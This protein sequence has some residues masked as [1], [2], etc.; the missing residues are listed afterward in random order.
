MSFAVPRSR[1]AWG[2]IFSVAAFSALVV[3]LWCFAAPALAQPTP[4]PIPGDFHGIRWRIVPDP[5][6]PDTV[7]SVRFLACRCNVQLVSGELTAQGVVVLHAQVHPSTV[8]AP[9]DLDSLDVALGKLAAGSYTQAVQI[10]ADLVDSLGQTH[11]E[12]GN[13]SAPFMVLQSCKPPLPGR[14]LPFLDEVKIGRGAP[15]ATCPQTACAGDSIPVHLSGHFPTTCVTL[16]SVKVVPSM[17]VGPQPEPDQIQITYATNTCSG[18]PCGDVV[19]PWQADVKITA[20]PPMPYGLVVATFVDDHCTAGTPKPAGETTLPF[21]VA[22]CESIPSMACFDARFVQAMGT[23]CDAYISPGQ[24]AHVTYE[25]A[26]TTSLA[27][28][29]GAFVFNQ[30]GFK[31]S[32]IQTTGAS[33]GMQLFWN[34][35]PNGAHFVL[36]SDHGELIPPQAPVWTN[37]WEPILQV[38]VDKIVPPPPSGGGGMAPANSVPV[39]PPAPVRLEAQD[40]LAA[41]SLG[42]AVP[43]CPPLPTATTVAQDR[44]ATI[45]PAGQASECDVNHDGRADVRDLVIMAMCIT[46]AGACPDTTG[47][48]LDCDGNG[49]V[50]LA[51]VMCCAHHILDQKRSGDDDQGDDDSHVAVDMSMPRPVTGGCDVPVA[52]HGMS[53][54]GAARL[55]LTFPSDRYDVTGVDLPSSPGW[56]SLSQ[57]GDGTVALAWIAAGSAASQSD[58]QYATIHL[59]LKAGATD[60]G[61]LTVSASQFASKSGGALRVSASGM[62]LPLSGGRVAL[63]SPLPNPSGGRTSFS[64]MLAQPG[65]L[66]VGVF[67]A[68]GRRIATLYHGNAPA[69]A[70]MMSWDGRR[71]S[72]VAAGAGLFFVRAESAGT[73]VTQKV[74]LLSPR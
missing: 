59:Q 62:S 42:H 29:Q 50:D 36:Y 22:P 23:V 37:P 71:D 60:G 57:H 9:C 40:L 67:D 18:Q 65:A 44:A 14:I 19:S 34:P 3:S 72:G 46:G 47:G 38:A 17:V 26:P 68:G 45:C 30:P 35:D 1:S 66:D 55:D 53:T 21:V 16:E 15:C 73:K 48:V 43:H 54:L 56:L 10:V 58:V 13:F 7:T 74:M 64:V 32:S 8:C 4:A 39:P 61:E 63:S 31:I 52:I 70:Q 6:C 28:L 41:D 25:I 33:S 49:V 5:T 24:S 20:L 11:T 2:A 27:G 12:T 51:D 69:G